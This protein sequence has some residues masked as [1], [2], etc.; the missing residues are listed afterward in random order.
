[1]APPAPSASLFTLEK[2]Q[3]ALAILDGHNFVHIPLRKLRV[4]SPVRRTAMPSAMVLR[5][6]R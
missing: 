3:I 1:M 2:Q 4:C 5:L 6:E